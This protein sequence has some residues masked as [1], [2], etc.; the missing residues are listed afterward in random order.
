M[1]LSRLCYDTSF[2]RLK[3]KEVINYT[4]LLQ[5]SGTIKLYLTKVSFS[6]KRSQGPFFCFC[7]LE[8]A[9]TFLV[10]TSSTLSVVQR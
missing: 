10:D 5:T 8:I 1:F 4:S 7:Q 9:T 3:K 2:G 6:L